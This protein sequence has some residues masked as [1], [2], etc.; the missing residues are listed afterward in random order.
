[1]CGNGVVENGEQ[2]DCGFR[3]NCVLTGELL[4]CDFT[5]CKLHPDA[6]CS[7]GLC[8]KDCKVNELSNIVYI[9]FP[10][11]FRGRYFFKNY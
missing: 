4:C 8:C 11:T 5:T 1:M 10:H 7:A 3:E 9:L 2:C 6:Q